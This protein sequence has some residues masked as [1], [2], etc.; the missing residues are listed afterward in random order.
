[1]ATGLAWRRRGGASARASRP[2]LC[3]LSSSSSLRRTPASAAFLRQTP[4]A[5][6]SS[7]PLL[8]P[9]SGG[10]SGASRDLL[11]P[12]GRCRGLA[13][14]PAAPRSAAC[15]TMTTC[16]TSAT[17]RRGQLGGAPPSCPTRLRW[18][19]LASSWHPKTPMVLL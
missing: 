18:S 2:N 17:P 10:C 6:S 14:R 9:Y 13:D 4:Q 16:G 1:M 8:L 7:P 11:L 3:F 15:Y 12:S 19:G 5:R